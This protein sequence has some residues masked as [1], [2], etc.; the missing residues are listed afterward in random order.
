MKKIWSSLAAGWQLPT[1][2]NGNGRQRVSIALRLMQTVSVLAGYLLV[3]SWVLLER[4]RPRAQ[5]TLDGSWDK[6][7]GASWNMAL[8]ALSESFL[9][10][11]LCLSLL[12]LA[13]FLLTRKR[14]VTRVHWVLI[15]LGMLGLISLIYC[16]L[17]F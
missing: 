15:V 3:V 4:S 8:A 16:R 6:K 5:G 1:S 11:S 7:V 9:V 12:G 14:Y 13:V 2:D 17:S 10:V